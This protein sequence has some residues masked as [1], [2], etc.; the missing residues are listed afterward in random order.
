MRSTTI[1]TL[2]LVALAMSGQA[3]AKKLFGGKTVGT[4]KPA[5]SAPAAAPAA[6][7]PKGMSTASKVAIG[8]GVGAAA[9]L[10]AGA[11]IAGAA[12]ASAPPPDAAPAAAPVAAPA[13]VDSSPRMAANEPA[14]TKLESEGT[15]ARAA[16]PVK[17]AAERRREKLEAEQ[18]AIAERKADARRAQLA[19]EASCQIKPVMTDA[20]ITNCKQAWR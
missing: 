8:A 5:A 7:A 19:R 2:T 16:M 10:V 13:V 11:A 14:V 3:D 20:E 4:A 9:G 1:A 12:P 17:T 15:K 18:R 6:A